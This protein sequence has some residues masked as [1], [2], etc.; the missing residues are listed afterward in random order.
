MNG[1]ELTIGVRRVV[2]SIQAAALA[3]ALVGVSAMP[4]AAA[5]KSGEENRVVGYHTVDRTEI[6]NLQRWVAAGHE[7]WCKDPRLVAAGEL[8]RIAVDF[9]DDATDLNAVDPGEGADTSD[10]SKKVAFEWTPLDGRATYRVTVE[11]FEWL[12]PIAKDAN[13][14]IWVPTITEIQIHE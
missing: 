3:T 14:V 11:R 2:R 5:A 6:E 12:L 7:D 9:A 4:A 13:A 1:K 8:Q 10:G